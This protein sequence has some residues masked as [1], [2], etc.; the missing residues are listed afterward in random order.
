MYASKSI[1]LGAYYRLQRC[2]QVA[3]RRADYGFLV[4]ARQLL[5]IN[6]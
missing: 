6:L 3:E 1:N 4:A 2:V 5:K